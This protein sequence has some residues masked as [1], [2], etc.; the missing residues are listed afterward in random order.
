MLQFENILLLVEHNTCHT[1]NTWVDIGAMEKIKANKTAYY[2]GY[3]VS[4]PDVFSTTELVW[5]PTNWAQLF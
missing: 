1:L 3:A 5:V 2:L 4:Y